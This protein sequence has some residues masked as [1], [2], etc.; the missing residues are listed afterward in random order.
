M[1]E[2][3][4]GTDWKSSHS[5]SLQRLGTG[6]AVKLWGPGMPW[7]ARGG[8]PGCKMLKC[9]VG[10]PAP[11]VSQRRTVSTSGTSLDSV[12]P[13]RYVPQPEVTFWKL[14]LQAARSEEVRRV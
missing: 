12:K 6:R 3:D 1:R 5:D 14:V 7:M 10:A 13:G 9:R 8:D 4:D 2:L 11:A